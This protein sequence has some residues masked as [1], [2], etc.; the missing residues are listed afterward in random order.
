MSTGASG[1][2]KTTTFVYKPVTSKFRFQ[3]FP[4]TPLR[5]LKPFDEFIDGD[6]ETEISE[7]M[8]DPETPHVILY[9]TPTMHVPGT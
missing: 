8:S 9:Q 1:Q 4:F 7:T 5:G 6:P 2:N 3:S